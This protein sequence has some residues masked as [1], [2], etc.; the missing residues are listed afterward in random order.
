MLRYLS[1]SSNA[2][3]RFVLHQRPDSGKMFRVNKF[4]THKGAPVR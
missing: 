3:L 1:K 2:A 4:L